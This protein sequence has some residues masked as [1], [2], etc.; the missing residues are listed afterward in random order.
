MLPSEYLNWIKNLS[1]NNQEK[2]FEYLIAR[3]KNGIRYF[4]YD[5]DY[6][7]GVQGQ[8]YQLIWTPAQAQAFPFTSEEEV[9]EFK[10][11]YISPRPASI[12]RVLRPAL[13]IIQ[14]M[15]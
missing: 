9:E 10:A 1:A 13:S 15:E 3:P 14:L 7:G 5:F 2:K 12:I 11:E 8:T 6:V 4:Y